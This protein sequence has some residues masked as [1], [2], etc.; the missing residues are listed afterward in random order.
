M[1]LYPPAFVKGKCVKGVSQNMELD[2]Q[3]VTEDVPQKFKTP[4]HRL[5]LYNS[6][7]IVAA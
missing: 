5:R 3:S 2:T 6:H 7:R 1:Q 4:P